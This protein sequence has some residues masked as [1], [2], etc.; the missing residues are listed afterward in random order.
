MCS[1]KPQN[2][3]RG[4]SLSASDDREQDLNM[5]RISTEI[6]KSIDCMHTEVNEVNGLTQGMKQL[7]LCSNEYLSSLPTRYVL[8]RYNVIYFINNLLTLYLVIDFLFGSRSKGV[9]LRNVTLELAVEKDA[10]AALCG[11]DGSGLDNLQQVFLL[12]FE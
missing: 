2:A 6:M 9:T 8:A 1:T 11:R 12:C 7:Q 5:L 4:D 10:L 3:G